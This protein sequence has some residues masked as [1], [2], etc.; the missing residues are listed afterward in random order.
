MSSAEPTIVLVG[1][2]W[3]EAHLYNPLTFA[4]R[5]AGY[6]VSVP[7]LPTVGG[8]QDDFSED[9]S[10]VREAV[11][12][13]TEAG[14]D[15]VVLM[16]SYGGV[17]GSEAVQ[18]LTRLDRSREDSKKGSVV[19]MIYLAAFALPEGISLL[20]AL[21]GKPLPW[22]EDAGNGWRAINTHEIFYNDV[23][24]SKADELTAQL[25]PQAKGVF[26]SKITYAAWKHIES[27]FI[28]C[29]KD[30]AIPVGGQEGMC[31]QDGNKFTAVRVDAS[32]SPWLSKLDETVTAIQGSIKGSL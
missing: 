14:N 29:E 5:D 19:Q 25:K 11:V 21:A 26:T 24:K 9:I 23:E 17:I 6:T 3:H 27:T 4:L 16:H 10:V 13:A 31:K 18:G 30:N 1:G 2:A 8:G 12:S 32:H 7:A 28:I 22:W 20:D 15:V